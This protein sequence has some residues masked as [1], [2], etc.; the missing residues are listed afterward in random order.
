M[1]RDGLSGPCASRL[2]AHKIKTQIKMTERG[3]DVE[4]VEVDMGKQERLPSNRPEILRTK[5]NQP[6]RI[7]EETEPERHTEY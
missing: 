1:D 2:E 5:R 6:D 3:V 7:C 4:D